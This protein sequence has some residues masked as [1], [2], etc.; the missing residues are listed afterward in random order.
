MSVPEEQMMAAMAQEAPPVS[1]QPELVGGVPPEQLPPEVTVADDVPRDVPENSFVL[2]GAAVEEAGLSDVA[3]MLTKAIK[4]ARELGIDIDKKFDNNSDEDIVKLLVSRGEVLI[5]EPFVRVIGLDRLKKMN[6]RGEK[7][8][9]KRLEEAQ[10]QEQAPQQ[11]VPLPQEQLIAQEG[12]QEPPVRAMATGGETGETERKGLGYAMMNP[13]DTY[14]IA[15]DIRDYAIEETNNLR[16]SYGTKA[17]AIDNELDTHRHLLGSFILHKEFSDLV[18]GG[19]LTYNEATGAIGDYAAQ[20]LDPKAATAEASREMDY[21]NNN[22]AKLLLS[23]VPPNKLQQMDRKAASY[24]VRAYM[25]EIKAAMQ[26]G[27]IEAIDPAMIPMFAPAGSESQGFVE[28]EVDT[29]SVYIRGPDNN[30]MENPN[31]PG[32]KARMERQNMNTGGVAQDELLRQFAMPPKEAPS[33]DPRGESRS[34]TQGMLEK[35]IIGDAVITP[36]DGLPPSMPMEIERMEPSEGGVVKP[37]HRNLPK[38]LTGE[39]FLQMKKQVVGYISNNEVSDEELNNMLSMVR[40]MTSDE[41]FMRALEIE[42]GDEIVGDTPIMSQFPQ[43]HF[44][45]EEDS[46]RIQD[47]N[48]RRD[49]VIESI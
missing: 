22:V 20:L 39:Q 16:K 32:N 2:S 23:R 21:H 5:P 8:V 15:T 24:Y 17:L 12:V 44:Y 46:R 4:R 28:P 9:S 31:H 42:R 41:E 33:G 26:D 19:I 45:D 18:A 25:D 43:N 10:Q 14:K 40:G 35:G 29:T 11:G 47:Y 34:I 27:S 7:E 38:V 1:N 49:E 37:E 30:W 36:R 13:I 6:A 3:D 48:D